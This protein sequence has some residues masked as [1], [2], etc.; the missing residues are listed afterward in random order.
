M[1]GSSIFSVLEA[2]ID[3]H[4]DDLLNTE[5]AASIVGQSMVSE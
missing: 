4:C 5:E 1:P 2:A 3:K